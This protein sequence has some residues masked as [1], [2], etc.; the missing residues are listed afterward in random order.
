MLPIKTVSGK[1]EKGKRFID[2]TIG[3][4]R[5]SIQQKNRINKMGEAPARYAG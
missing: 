3:K 5:L 4:A 1:D 2:K